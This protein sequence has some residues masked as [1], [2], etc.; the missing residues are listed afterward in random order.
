MALGDRKSPEQTNQA[1]SPP[2]P[3]VQENGTPTKRVLITSLLAGF[4]MLLLTFGIY[5]YV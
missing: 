3:I 1:L 4:A 5:Y 2:T